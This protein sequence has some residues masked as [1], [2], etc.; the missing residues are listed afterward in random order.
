MLMKNWLI[1]GWVIFTIVF[2]EICPSI[3]WSAIYYV[4]FVSG[5]NE[6]TGTK[7]SPKQ[8]I[9]AT[10][11]AGDIVYLKRGVSYNANYTFSNSGT[12][13]VKNENGSHTAGGNTLTSATTNFAASGVTTADHV[14]IN[15]EG[16]FGIASVGTTS[17]T[18]TTT[19]KHTS[20]G[21][22]FC[23]ANNITI[24]IDQSW[25]TGSAIFKGNLNLTGRNYIV[26]DGVITKG[27]EFTNP[28]SHYRFIDTY[29]SDTGPYYYGII[30]RN[31]YFHDNYPV[32][33]G[34]SDYGAIKIQHVSH[35][36]LQNLIIE[37]VGTQAATLDWGN[38]LFLFYLQY[39]TIDNN[40][41][42]RVAGDG[43][44]VGGWES[45]YLQNTEIAY[46]GYVHC[47]PS[48]DVHN[49]GL[50]SVGGLNNFVMRY[51]RIHDNPANT[52]L[53]GMTNFKMYN[54]LI[55]DTILQG[56]Y[57]GNQ[58][59]GGNEGL[60][61]ITSSGEIYNNI[62]AFNIYDA[63]HVGWGY[64]CAGPITIKNNIFY[65]ND[66]LNGGG[67]EVLID[68]ECT[69]VT[70]LDHN[71]YIRKNKPVTNDKIINWG[72][73]SYSLAQARTVGL[74]TNGKKC[75]AV[76]CDWTWGNPEVFVD[77]GRSNPDFR[78]ALSNSSQ[79]GTGVSIGIQFDFNGFK[80]RN[81]PSIG[82][83]E[84]AG[85]EYTLPSSSIP[86]PPSDL[87]IN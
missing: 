15:G 26:V 33:D 49:D 37:D 52:Q 71:I 45:G 54:N 19:T 75:T 9:P 20:T 40:V 25:G 38:G 56:G 44:Q 64:S 83:F 76:G 8:N 72:G 22:A 32:Y 67:A 42:K 55:Y 34:I 70:T 79:V 66:D 1:W 35:S 63:I 78:P 46:S 13:K 30:L 5:R 11:A 77:S 51:N 2:V 6:N 4:D 21:V 62:I 82:A 31:L 10:L 87:I 74:E 65:E 7:A 23:V 60:R 12:L 36:L 39:T 50:Q 24:T 59:G 29:N 68:K 57:C 48:G 69:S 80:F 84:Y 61:I 17:L 81:P 85:S 28:V 16:W 47:V 86:S 73:N 27:I 3:S 18:L 41:I 58:L 43:I 53:N 14:F